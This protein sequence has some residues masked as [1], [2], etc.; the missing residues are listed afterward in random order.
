MTSPLSPK[1]DIGV[2]IS[3]PRRFLRKAF[4]VSDKTLIVISPELVKSLHI[5]EETWIE[6]I[7]TDNGILLTIY[8]MHEQKR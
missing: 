6:E 2:S 1:Q 8:D 7:E 3:I 5:N 4:I